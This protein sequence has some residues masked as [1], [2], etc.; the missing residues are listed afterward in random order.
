MAP[1][2]SATYCTAACAYKASRSSPA[3]WLAAIRWRLRT[4]LESIIDGLFT[5]DTEWWF[6]YVNL[7]AGSEPRALVGQVLWRDPLSQ[8]S[9]HEFTIG[10]IVSI[11]FA[12][13]GIDSLGSGDGDDI[14]IGGTFGDTLDSGKGDNVVLGDHGRILALTNEGFNSVVG[15]PRPAGDRPLTYALITSLVPTGELGGNDTITTGIGRDIVIGGAGNDV[16]DSFSSESLGTVAGTAFADGNNIVI[17]DYGL[18]DYLSGELL[19]GGAT[20]PDLF[21][22]VEGAAAISVFT[23]PMASPMSLRV[24]SVPPPPKRRSLPSGRCVASTSENRSELPPTMSSWPRLPKTTS[25]PPPPS[26]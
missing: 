14:L 18:V 9:V 11:S 16:F 15:A 22:Y 7:E 17:S 26:T 10:E 4:I 2:Y 6:D 12:D 25:L 23:N 5:L 8:I 19:Q 20:N 21:A 1:C 3:A 13:G 24:M